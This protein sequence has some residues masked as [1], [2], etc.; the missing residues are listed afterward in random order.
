[1]ILVLLYFGQICIEILWLQKKIRNKGEKNEQFKYK[2]NLFDIF[3]KWG[4]CSKWMTLRQK[5]VG[6]L[7]VC[8]SQICEII[9]FMDIFI[10]YNLFLSR[11]YVQMFLL[12]FSMYLGWS[13]FISTVCWGHTLCLSRGEH[14]PH[15][16]TCC[17][18]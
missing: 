16:S 5:P 17:D 18:P 1:M 7:L 11:S 3:C 12:Y 4:W 14:G 8:N 6:P 9:N 13:S 10:V 2:R 15:C